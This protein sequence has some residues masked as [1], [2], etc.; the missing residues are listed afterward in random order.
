MLENLILDHKSIIRQIRKD[1]DRAEQ[2]GDIGIADFLTEV[3]QK[4]KRLA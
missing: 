2:L 4:M 1:T 3:I